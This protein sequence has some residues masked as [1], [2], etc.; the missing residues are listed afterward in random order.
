[1]FLH[2]YIANAGPLIVCGSPRSGT[3]F[4]ANA[5]HAHPEI[6]LN[7]EIPLAAMEDTERWLRGLETR[8]WRWA[9]H[10][11][12]RGWE[13]GW[14]A[15]RHLLIYSIWAS[16]FKGEFK[17]PDGPVRWY[18]YK[19]PHHERFWPLWRDLF[20]AGMQ[21]KYVYCT[22]NFIDHYRSQQ[23]KT[24]KMDI[25]KI[26]NNYRQ[27]INTYAEMKGELGDSVSLFILDELK[28]GGVEYVKMV[29]FDSLGIAAEDEVLSSINPLRPANSS[30]ALGIEKEP[31]SDEA[32]RFIDRNADLLY[33]VDAAR[34]GT[35]IAAS[36]G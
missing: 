20:P 33:A 14:Q 34:K 30:P 29:L 21:P 8:Y 22:R 24:P 23:A 6:H 3:R 9:E 28:D 1:M 11:R 7:G 32:R 35:G 4:V 15:N 16:L 2:P 27:S 31:L 26:A 18:G 13:W 25:G 12:R 10:P 36:N 17:L 19:T 5:L